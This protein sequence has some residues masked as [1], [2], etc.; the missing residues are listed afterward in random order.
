MYKQRNDYYLPALWG[1][2]V[3]MT[4]GRHAGTHSTVTAVS[5]PENKARQREERR[6]ALEESIPLLLM[7]RAGSHRRECNDASFI[8]LERYS[9]TAALQMTS[10]L[11]RDG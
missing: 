10:E 5:L 2:K 6:A 3:R 8:E 9:P 7:A 4:S 1:G 11:Y